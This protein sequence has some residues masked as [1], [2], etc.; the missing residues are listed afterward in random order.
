MARMRVHELAKEL[1]IES[2]EMLAYLKDAGEF[3]KSASSVVE[4]PVVKRMME[5]FETVSYTHLDVYKRQALRVSPTLTPRVLALDCSTPISVSELGRFPST[6]ELGS[7]TGL[8]SPNTEADTV[9]RFA[10]KSTLMADRV[11]ICHSG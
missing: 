1:G 9:L 3:V 8:P 7:N 6:T 11:R 2:K 5:R 10:D 4:S